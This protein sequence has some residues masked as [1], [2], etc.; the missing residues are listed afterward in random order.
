MLRTPH[1]RVQLPLS[2]SPPPP[3]PDTALVWT[4]RRISKIV[5]LGQADARL[6]A[7][8]ST[9]TCIWRPSAWCR[10]RPRGNFRYYRKRETKP[11][12]ILSHFFMQ[13]LNHF[14]PSEIALQFD[15]IQVFWP[16][17]QGTKKA[18]FE[19]KQSRLSTECVGCICLSDID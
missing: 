7:R 2:F 18:K 6:E 19:I 17:K 8:S 3:N 15:P 9:T 13:N 5:R 1:L 16:I 12:L 14:F 10:T 11:S 4:K